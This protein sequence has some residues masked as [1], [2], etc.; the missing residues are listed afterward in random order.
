MLR[1]SEGRDTIESLFE[2]RDGTTGQEFSLV[3]QTIMMVQFSLCSDLTISGR[4]TTACR[5]DFS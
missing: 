5:E 2:E 4:P 1:T 3:A